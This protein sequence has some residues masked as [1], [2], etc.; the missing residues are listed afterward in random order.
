[1]NPTN[2]LLYLLLAL[3]LTLGKPIGS[4][5]ARSTYISGRASDS[6]PAPDA[7]ES[8]ERLRCSVYMRGVG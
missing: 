6:S 7:R 8:P 4:L 2:T 3:P 1:M 5:E